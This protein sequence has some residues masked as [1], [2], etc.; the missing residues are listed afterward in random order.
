[1]D[2]YRRCVIK[3]FKHDGHLHRMWFRN[4]SVP[5]SRLLPEHKAEGMHVLINRQTPIREA[6]G[7][8]WVSRVSAVSF[9]IPGQWFNVVALL[10]DSGTRYY[11]N[12]ASPPYISG[13]VLTYIDYDLDVIRTAGGEMHVVDRD[14]Y[15]LHKAE[16]KYPPI[17]DAKTGQGLGELQRR[18]MNGS[19]PFQD[20]AALAYYEDWLEYMEGNLS[21]A[22]L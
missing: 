14:E 18:I 7:G 15:E 19:S 13:D 4:W 20:E 3:S 10:E 11:C 9:F 8:M 5:R 17:I 2:T 12:I 21:E 1:M 22:E 6:D 16:Y